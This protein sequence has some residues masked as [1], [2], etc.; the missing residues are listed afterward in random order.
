M[1]GGD[2]KQALRGEIQFFKLF[3]TVIGKY[4]ETREKIRIFKG[5]TSFQVFG[6]TYPPQKAH[7]SGESEA[8]M[9]FL[10]LWEE[11]PYELT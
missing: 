10:P 9:D 1:R 6:R 7:Y 3:L 11:P 5:S 8:G 4:M 2:T